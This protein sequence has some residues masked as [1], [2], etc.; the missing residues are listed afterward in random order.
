MRPRVILVLCIFVALLSLVCITGC[1]TVNQYYSPTQT[2]TMTPSFG[3]PTVTLPLKGTPAASDD[4]WVAVETIRV[5]ATGSAASGYRTQP[6]MS[7]VLKNNTF[8]KIQVKGTYIWC[9]TS[10]AFDAIADAEWMNV[11]NNTV[12]GDINGSWVKSAH[13]EPWHD[14]VIDEK[15]VDWGP[16]QP[17]HVYSTQ[18]M[19]KGLPVSLRITDFCPDIG[20]EGCYQDNSGYLT[21]SIFRFNESATALSGIS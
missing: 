6:V 9:N 8:Y 19:G 20:K 16:Y 18:V 4:P 21:V 13:P 15:D 1:I 2:P 7:V 12:P 3:S 11:S 5:P 14:L 17:D 10:T